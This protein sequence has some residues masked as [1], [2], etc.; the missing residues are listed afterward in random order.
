MKKHL[1][2]MLTATLFA[3]AGAAIAIGAT[4]LKR[5]KEQ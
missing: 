2:E 3:L 1:W 4:F 5:T